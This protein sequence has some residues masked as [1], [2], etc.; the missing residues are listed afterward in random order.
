VLDER[1]GKALKLLN[2]SSSTVR[3][4]A[5][6]HLLD[7]FFKIMEAGH[8]SMMLLDI[9]V[10]GIGA[11]LLVIYRKQIFLFDFVVV[12]NHLKLRKAS[13]FCKDL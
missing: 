8:E 11:E 3:L 13:A 6:V 9:V 4:C 2:N 1:I 10:H 7:I 5:R 12:P